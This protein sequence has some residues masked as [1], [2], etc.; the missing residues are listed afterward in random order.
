MKDFILNYLLLFLTRLFNGVPALLRKHNQLSKITL[1]PRLTV[2]FA[3]NHVAR[4]SEK[5]IPQEQNYIFLLFTIFKMHQNWATFSDI[6]VEHSI[7]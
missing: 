2:A 1:M 7:L 6:I 4:N 5:D 3:S